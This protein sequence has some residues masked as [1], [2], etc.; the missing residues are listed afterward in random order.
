MTPNLGSRCG[1][2]D[3]FFSL[4]LQ[5]KRHLAVLY[6]KSTKCRHGCL[7]YSVI[8]ILTMQKDEKSSKQNDKQWQHAMAELFHYVNHYG[9]L[10]GLR[11]R[12][13]ARATR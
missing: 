9:G 1:L 2:C 3:D 10:F 13:K 11:E 4:F 8:I 12:A 7:Y 5:Q 6:Y